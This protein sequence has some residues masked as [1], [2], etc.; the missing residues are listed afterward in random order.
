MYLL[1]ADEQAVDGLRG[2]LEGLGD[3]LVV[4]GG[5]GLWNVHVH[6][7]DVGAAVEA[8]I[9]AG[10][11]H[12]VR[13]THFA[14]QAEARRAAERAARRVTATGPA[15]VARG[16][17]WWRSPR[18]RA[19][20]RCSP[21]RARS[22]SH[23]GPGHRPAARDLLEA[24]LAS[25]AAEMVL[26]PNDEDSLGVADI[27]ARTGEEGGRARVEVVPSRTQ[28]QGLAALAV[29]EPGRSFDADLVAMASAARSV[30]HGAVT[31]AGTRAMTTAG[32][33]E[34]G[35]V[36]G[37]IGGDFAVIGADLPGW[38]WRCWSG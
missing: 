27:A 29:H 34:V 8:G 15:Y 28:V 30:R 13:V 20:Q 5:E 4:V 12:H 26:L 14:E 37:V 6:V 38:R 16:A 22:S 19:W 36:L 18:A 35:D 25:E 9:V 2:T 23:G 33:C 32:P 17:P 10:R 7:D 11:P 31:V 3:S 21:R 1:D 24:M